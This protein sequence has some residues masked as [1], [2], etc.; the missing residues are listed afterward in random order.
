MSRNRRRLS[1]QPLEPRKL[2]AGDAFGVSGVDDP[3]VDG[4][5][6][7]AVIAD[8]VRVGYEDASTAEDDVVVDGRI[9]TAE[10][11]DS[12]RSSDPT[13]A[14][15]SE[16]GDNSTTDTNRST[17]IEILSFSHSMDQP[18]S[19]QG[20]RA[21]ADASFSADTDTVPVTSSGPRFGKV[22]IIASGP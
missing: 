16:L 13:D 9:I 8:A 15:F 11:Y 4:D 21:N 3:A 17:W 5:Q 2:M 10:N 18:V 12:A 19:M 1:V 20:G 7:T 14:F 22:V 6:S